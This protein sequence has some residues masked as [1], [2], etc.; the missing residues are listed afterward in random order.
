M[1]RALE[2][3]VSKGIPTHEPRKI[4]QKLDMRDSFFYGVYLIDSFLRLLQSSSKMK[5]LTGLSPFKIE[6]SGKGGDTGRRTKPDID[7]RW[8]TLG[9]SLSSRDISFATK[10]PNGKYACPRFH[11]SSILNVSQ[12]RRVNL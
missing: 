9:E 4:P 7:S 10:Q 1:C 8:S 2:R 12:K 5:V 11:Q 6:K 3:A